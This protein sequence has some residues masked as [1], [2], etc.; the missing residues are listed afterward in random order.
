MQIIRI[1]TRSIQYMIVTALAYIY[2]RFLFN[3][4][5]NTENCHRDSF[6]KINTSDE[7]SDF[8]PHWAKDSP[9]E[10][11]SYIDSLSLYQTTLYVQVSE[12]PQNSP[13]VYNRNENLVPHAYTRSYIIE[14]SNLTDGRQRIVQRRKIG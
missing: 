14:R 1:Y 8:S 11:T 10:K 5:E 6:I 2:T 12:E 7:S 4:P 13:H 3:T 9:P